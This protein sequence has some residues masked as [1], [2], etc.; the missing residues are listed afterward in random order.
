[1][2]DYLIDVIAGL[3]KIDT[4]PEMVERSNEFHSVIDS[5]EQ[6]VANID[7]Q[8]LRTIHNPDIEIMV[9]GDDP[10]KKF[11]AIK[12][13]SMPDQLLNPLFKALEMVC[14]FVEFMIFQD[15]NV[16]HYAYARLKPYWDFANQSVER[17][18]DVIKPYFD[19]ISYKNNSKLWKTML[20]SIEED[21][22]YLRHSD[23]EPN[24]LNAKA[25]FE[26]LSK[27]RAIPQPDEGGLSHGLL[28]HSANLLGSHQSPFIDIESDD[29]KKTQVLVKNID[30][31]NLIESSKAPTRN[32]TQESFL[33]FNI[34]D[35]IDIG[36]S[37]MDHSMIQLS[38]SGTTYSF[39]SPIYPLNYDPQK[40][41]LTLLY[42]EES[43]AT[44]AEFAEIYHAHYWF[45]RELIAT[46]TN[47]S[48]SENP[49]Q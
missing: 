48:R 4:F 17:L 10:K 12:D 36:I 14:S 39:K 9:H 28:D 32:D 33:V 13:Q 41:Q 49:S 34:P 29:G 45:V 40:K 27:L 16:E 23:F 7:H 18:A 24:R 20:K 35:G 25:V 2:G 5:L 11:L 37:P 42:K 47:F 26:Y 43:Y 31:Y 8:T 30:L 46:F 15:V 19:H 38:K 6:H 44:E 21:M 3:S 1:M 22:Y